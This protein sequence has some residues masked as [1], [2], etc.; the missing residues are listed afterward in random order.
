[1]K[2]KIGYKHDDDTCAAILSTDDKASHRL[3]F[4]KHW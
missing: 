1:M 4:G 3:T 2:K